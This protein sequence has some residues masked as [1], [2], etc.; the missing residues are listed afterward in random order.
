MFQIFVESYGYAIRQPKELSTSRTEVQ[1]QE[2][3]GS[4]Y[5][6]IEAGQAILQA[7]KPC[8][9]TSYATHPFK[10]SR[11]LTNLEFTLPQPLVPAVYPCTGRLGWLSIEES[12][13]NAASPLE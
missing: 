12:T 8:I 9:S 3:L 7:C 5:R 11:E 1:R 4:L 10:T 2:K 13:A 6:T